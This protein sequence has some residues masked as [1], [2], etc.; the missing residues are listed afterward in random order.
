MRLSAA[1]ALSSLARLL[2]GECLAHTI[3][4]E[5]SILPGGLLPKPGA[6]FFPILIDIFV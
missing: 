1:K 6:L 2:R 5:N 4:R 3:T